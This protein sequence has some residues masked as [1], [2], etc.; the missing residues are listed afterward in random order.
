MI[1]QIGDSSVASVALKRLQEEIAELVDAVK[2]GNR[3]LVVDE[4]ADVVFY[5]NR[6]ATACGLTGEL[7]VRYSTVKSAL[8][9]AGLRNKTVELRLA[10]EFVNEA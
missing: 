3:V 1:Q 4:L 9:D 10:A 2:S 8:R 5:T 6:V 7:I